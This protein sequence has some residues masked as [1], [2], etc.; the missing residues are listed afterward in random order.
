[1]PTRKALIALGEAGGWNN[2]CVSWRSCGAARGSRDSRFGRLT[3]AARVTGV[4]SLGLVVACCIVALGAGSH[5]RRTELVAKD[6]ILS[7]RQRSVLAEGIA[8]Q[9]EQDAGRR[10]PRRMALTAGKA[11]SSILA[12]CGA[13]A[14]KNAASMDRYRKRAD[15]K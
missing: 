5:L 14:G 3:A 12:M 10:M 8:R 13:G 11:Y 1:M 9:L 7:A 15:A 4:A 6:Q 2:A